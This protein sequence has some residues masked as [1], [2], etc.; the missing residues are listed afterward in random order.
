MLAIL[1]R[2]TLR[3]IVSD[4][5][6]D[7]LATY[8]KGAVSEA[9]QR[10]HVELVR[11]ANRFSQEGSRLLKVA[12]VLGGHKDWNADITLD[13]LEVQAGLRDAPKQKGRRG[14]Q[15]RKAMETD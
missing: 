7:E 1:R 6:H 15:A 4:L 11:Q 14:A 2:A 5:L 10:R 9:D 8:L 3:R 13:T 12:R